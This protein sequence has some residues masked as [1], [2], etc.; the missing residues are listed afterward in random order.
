MKRHEIVRFIWSDNI[1]ICMGKPLNWCRTYLCVYL[2][3]EGSMKVSTLVSRLKHIKR[4]K[5]LSVVCLQNTVHFT[6][7][8]EIKSCLTTASLAPANVSSSS[9]RS[10]KLPTFRKSQSMKTTQPERPN[11]RA[12]VGTRETSERKVRRERCS[13]TNRVVPLPCSSPTDSL[14]SNRPAFLNS[15]V[16]SG[17]TVT[18]LDDSSECFRT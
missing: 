1:S 3:I 9:Y 10:C 14:R 15:L 17:T 16:T 6:L 13:R 11:I 7:T 5:F 18:L 2:L 12:I 4:P 8:E